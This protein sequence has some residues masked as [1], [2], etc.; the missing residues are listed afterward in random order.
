[1]LI[2]GMVKYSESY[3]QHE[4]WY[5]WLVGHGSFMAQ[6]LWLLAEV[7]DICKTGVGVLLCSIVDIHI[8]GGSVNMS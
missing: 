5:D 1:M 4:A 7:S 6:F 3:P 8:P 2:A